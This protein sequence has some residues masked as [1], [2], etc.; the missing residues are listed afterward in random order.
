M[1]DINN[2]NEN[3]Q[4]EFG[5]Y[6][7]LYQLT[8]EQIEENSNIEPKDYLWNRWV[9]EGLSERQKE[10]FEIYSAP[11]GWR[12]IRDSCK[13]CDAN[14]EFLSL[15]DKQELLRKINIRLQ[16]MGASYIEDLSPLNDYRWMDGLEDAT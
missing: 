7:W 1:N 8:Q 2:R 14:V 13:V 3:Q 6:Y 11:C 4:Q 12:E 15:E 10:E 16:E 9:I 5:L